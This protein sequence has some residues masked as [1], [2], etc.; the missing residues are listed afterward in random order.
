MSYILILTHYLGSESKVPNQ[1]RIAWHFSLCHKAWRTFDKIQPNLFS[2]V[3][4]YAI[5]KQKR[6]KVVWKH[7]TILTLLNQNLSRLLDRNESKIWIWHFLKSMIQ[8]YQWP[9]Q[10]S[11][12]GINSCKVRKNSN[13][14]TLLLVKIKST[15]TLI[16]AV[17]H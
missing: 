16:Y 2:N 3:N 13:C 4:N 8:R 6:T 12:I 11:C 14:E 9:G 5:D 1:W 7:T 15:L 10:F 17:K